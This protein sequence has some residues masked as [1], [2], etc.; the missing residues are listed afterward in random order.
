MN[1]EIIPKN[2]VNSFKY[3]EDALPFSVHTIKEMS[4]GITKWRSGKISFN[5][6]P[7]YHLRHGSRLYASTAYNLPTYMFFLN[8]LSTYIHAHIIV[9]DDK[10]EKT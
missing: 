1:G 5:Y 10:H 7:K 4:A 3:L 9:L 8:K 6:H 2:K